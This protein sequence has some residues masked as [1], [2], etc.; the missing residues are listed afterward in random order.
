MNTIGYIYQTEEQAQNA[1][2]LC[3]Q[4]YGIPHSPEDTT[5]QYTDYLYSVGNN[6]YY[7]IFDP[8]LEIVLGEPEIFEIIYPP[9][10]GSTENV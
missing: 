8:T 2:E 3:N 5:T 9:I 4:Y 6:F 1:V 10:T 7:I